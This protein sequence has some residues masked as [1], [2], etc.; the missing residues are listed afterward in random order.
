MAQVLPY[1]D[2]IDRLT[3]YLI[4]KHGEKVFVAP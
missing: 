3:D 4:A 2:G 1:Q